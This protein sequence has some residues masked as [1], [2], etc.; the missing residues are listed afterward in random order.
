M[1]RRILAALV[2]CTIAGFV[3]QP[4]FAQT[5]SILGTWQM[6]L[7]PNT[8]PSPPTIPVAALGTFHADNTAEATGGGVLV[9]PI[10]SSGTTTLDG[11][12]PALGYWSP[13]PGPSSTLFVLQFTSLITN[14]NG[15][16]FATRSFTATVNVNA[17]NNQFSGSYSFTI[18]DTT[19]TVI[20]TGS[21]SISGKLIPRILPPA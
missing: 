12:T 15:S 14:E 21:G 6:T 8:P 3:A 19:D 20:E 7:I 18:T 13:G 11:P 9:G 17:N 1:P 5:P 16:L 2:L 10:P 4:A